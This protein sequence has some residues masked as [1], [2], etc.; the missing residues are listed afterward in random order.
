MIVRRLRFTSIATCLLAGLVTGQSS[1]TWWKYIPPEATAVVGI[2]WKQLRTTMFAGAV[3]AELAPGGDLGFPDLEIL[4][5]AEQILIGSPRLLAIEYGTFPHE[6]LREQATKQSFT[7]RMVRNAELWLNPEKESLSVAY[8]SE[9]LLLVGSAATLESEIARVADPKSR[10]FSP[11]LARG[12]RYIKEDLWVVASG[13]PDPLASAFIPFDWTATAF[14]GSVS[15]WDGLHAV[16][17][18]ERGN[19]LLAMDLADS[20]AMSLASR[21]AMAEG[22]EVTTHDRSVLIRMDLDEEQL[23]LSMRPTTESTPA[24]VSQIHE[25]VSTLEPVVTASSLAAAPVASPVKKTFAGAPAP[26]KP[27]APAASK[28]VVASLPGNSKPVPAAPVVS[29][30]PVSATPAKPE[31]RA[32]VAPPATHATAQT[33]AITLPEVDVRSDITPTLQG[34]APQAALPPKPRVIRIVGL[35]DGPREIMLDKVAK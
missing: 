27:A 34:S 19:P 8:I 7:R 15:L 24:T 11:L 32:F 31:A 6:K 2:Q 5:S 28:P 22:T 14:E 1:P 16:A 17:A 35:D 30:V 9:K 18:I 20:I 33:A 23:A 3:S 4:R 29:I 12:A 10:S 25:P 13:L 21:P 26:A